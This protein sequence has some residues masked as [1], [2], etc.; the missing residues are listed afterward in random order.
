MTGCAL[1]KLIGYSIH[2]TAM[3]TIT[4]HYLPF[5]QE[6]YL[7][8]LLKLRLLYTSYLQ[9]YITNSGIRTNFNIWLPFQFFGSNKTV[10][11]I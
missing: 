2:Y 8:S 9:T 5:K 6:M 7:K 4:C 3:Q 10:D 11:L 1:N